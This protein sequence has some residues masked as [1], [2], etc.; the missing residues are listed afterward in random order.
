MVVGLALSDSDVCLAAEAWLIGEVAGVTL[1]DTDVSLVIETL[2]GVLVV[3]IWLDAAVV[4]LSVSFL[5]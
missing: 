4:L 2:C 3:F 5:V 1:S